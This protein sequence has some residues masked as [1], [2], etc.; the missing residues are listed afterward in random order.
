MNVLKHLDLMENVEFLPYVPID[1]EVMNA[2]VHQEHL[3]IHSLDVSN[4]LINNCW[5][6]M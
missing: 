3:E 4:K 2:D 6:S 5:Y 1:Q